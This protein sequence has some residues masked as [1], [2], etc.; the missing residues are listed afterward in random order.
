M[1]LKWKYLLLVWDKLKEQRICINGLLFIINKFT[2][3]CILFL[4]KDTAPLFC[5]LSSKTRVLP[6]KHSRTY[7]AFSSR[8]SLPTSS[9]SAY[10][11]PWT[12]CC[13]FHRQLG[14]PWKCKMSCH[15]SSAQ[16]SAWTA[17]DRKTWKFQVHSTRRLEDIPWC[18]VKINGKTRA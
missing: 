5:G 14:R 4:R 13:C 9:S 6:A 11:T 3:S 15:R 7:F 2:I 1:K 10:S 16:A 18:Q 17:E 8:T 12:D